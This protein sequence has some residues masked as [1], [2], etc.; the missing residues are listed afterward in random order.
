MLRA[1]VLMR[2]RSAFNFV[3]GREIRMLDRGNAQKHGHSYVDRLHRETI[4]FEEVMMTFLLPAYRTRGSQSV[5]RE[6]I[7]LKISL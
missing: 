7:F 6:L 2:V 5:G 4:T 1:Y 3:R